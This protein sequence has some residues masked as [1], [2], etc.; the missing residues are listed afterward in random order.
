MAR[1]PDKPAPLAGVGPHAT[2]TNVTNLA[3]PSASVPTRPVR[4]APKSGRA[5]MRSDGAIVLTSTAPLA[6]YP[7]SWN[8]KIEQW[9]QEA[10]SRV[11]LTESDGAGG[12]RT[13]TYAETLAAVESI[14]EGLLNLGLNA[15]TPLAVLAEN[16]IE[17]ALIT[18]AAMWVGVPASPVS[19]PYAL[20]ATDFTKL[21]GVFAALQPGAIYV[22]DGARYGAAIQAAAPVDA[23]IISGRAP[24]PGRETIALTDLR[25]STPSAR[26]A[27]ANAAVTG[28][29]IA[30]ILFTS[31]SSG[32]PKPVILPHGMLAVN[33]QQCAQAY[34]FLNDGPPVMV[35]WLPWHHTFGG[36]NNLGQ[37]LW[38]GGELHIDDGGPTPAGIGRT[39]ELLRAHPPTFYINTPG[40]FEALL[41]YLRNDKHFAQRFF[42]RLQL[43]QYGGALLAQHVWRAIDE[44]A[45]ATTGERILMVSGLGSTECG[46]TPVQSTWEQHRKPEAGLPL[47]GVEAK[48]VPVETTWELRLRGPCVTPGYWRRP[49]LTAAAFDD[50]GFFKTG[51]AVLP[52]DPEDFSQGLLF[53]GRISENFKLSSG[54]WVQAVALRTRLL[55]ALAPLVNDAVITGHNQGQV[56]AIAFPDMNVARKIAS[57]HTDLTDEEV[58]AAPALRDWV[59][60]RVSTLAG[61]AVGA[62]ERI[63]RLA[64]ETEAPSFDNGELTDKGAAASRIVLSRRIDVVTALHAVTPPAAIFI[65]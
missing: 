11:F 42:S 50:E 6:P 30:K 12:R 19:P 65:A 25:N 33:R 29:T 9:A 18:L 27:K 32:A 13:I 24:I 7:Q 60:T 48:L 36:N 51:D 58:L 56:G 16:S 62:S 52:L 63:A 39:V 37:I 44:I 47:A 10:P 34:A 64:L 57:A 54:T 55:A 17:C 31:G 23:V 3:D 59:Q 35:D 15:E 49:D 46:P 21:S 14:G 43:L 20:K 4:L 8:A 61:S 28:D 53:D 40:A 1:P 38:C 2:V 26:T 45:V 41:P 22:A 5:E